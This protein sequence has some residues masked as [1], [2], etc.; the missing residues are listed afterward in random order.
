M[1]SEMVNLNC[2]VI[3]DLIPLCS[4]GLCSETSAQEIEKHIAACERCRMLYENIPTV[5][6]P[7]LEVPDESK[8]FRKVRKKMKRS[9]LKIALLS[10]AL[11]AVVIPV[12]YLSCGQIVKDASVQ[13]FETV[14]QSFEV[15]QLVKKLAEGDIAGYMAES[16]WG[17]CAEINAIDF[18]ITDYA[19]IREKDT[20]NLQ[21]AYDA[22][23]GDT[24]VERIKVDSEYT[25]TA[26]EGSSLVYSRAVITYENGKQL[27]VDFT[28]R[29]DGLYSGHF[30]GEDA[31]E[32]MRAFRRALNYVD[33]HE[34]VPRGWF[35]E[36]LLTGDSPLNDAQINYAMPGILERFAAAYHTQVEESITAFYRKGYLVEDCVLNLRYDDEKQMLYHETVLIASDAQGTAIMNTRLYS[37]YE[38]LIPPEEDMTTIY[39]D[40]CSDALAED[41]AHLF[42]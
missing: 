25:E 23:F 11:A 21:R 28:K 42:G 35:E 30:M 26:A 27:M 13:S 33:E 19:V 29:E 41:L 37:T 5:E 31:T 4:E 34:L 18:T 15:R 20:E 3:R 9:R 39:R 16:S 1:K 14:W 32:E 12:V 22:A 8:P 17:D 24:K 36:L 6:A 40:G 2:E 10:I 7:K 38:G